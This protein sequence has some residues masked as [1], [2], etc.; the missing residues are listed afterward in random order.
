VVHGV[1]EVHYSPG[2][3]NAGDAAD[4]SN[5]D[6]ENGAGR[7]AG[8]AGEGF[9]LAGL[10]YSGN[11]TATHPHIGAT[12]VLLLLTPKMGPRQNANT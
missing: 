5:V 8:K 1:A 11:R 6:G 9:R 3:P 4:V 7:Q 12:G 2:A 10:D